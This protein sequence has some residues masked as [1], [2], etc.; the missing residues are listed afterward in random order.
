MT[1][2]RFEV[3]DR[4]RARVANPSGHTRLPTYVRGRQGVIE[5]VRRGHPLPDE[6]VREARK[7]SSQPVYSVRF[8][9]AELWGPDAEPASE[10]IMELWE[11]Y[12]DS[13]D[14]HTL[15]RSAPPTAGE[16]HHA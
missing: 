15:S 8:A 10:L 11:P 6:T 2:P 3:G 12:L 9:M 7:G 4:V 16:D 5:S 1:A 14:D 13:L